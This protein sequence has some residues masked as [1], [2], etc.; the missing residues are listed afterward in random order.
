MISE[1]ANDLDVIINQ[2]KG[3]M[4]RTK[5]LLKAIDALQLKTH[6]EPDNKIYVLFADVFKMLTER[7]FKRSLKDEFI[8]QNN[9]I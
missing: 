1:N 7:A 4:L 5:K 8:I 2:E 3:Y 6:R 9:P